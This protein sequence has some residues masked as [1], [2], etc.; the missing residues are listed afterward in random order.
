MA[1]DTYN[2][3]QIGRGHQIVI[4]KG[5]GLK[6][7]LGNVHWEEVASDLTDRF[8]DLIDQV[9]SSDDLSA[10][11]KR[12]ILEAIEEA[13]G[14]LDRPSQDR[15][16]SKIKGALAKAAS[17]ATAAAPIATAIAQIAGLFA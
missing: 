4:Q 17:L 3:H 1:G 16:T 13:T 8:D 7:R 9:M 14:E 12:E 11:Q 6:A 10:N 15:D 2:I 5:Q